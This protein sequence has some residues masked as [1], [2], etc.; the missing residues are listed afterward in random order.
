MFKNNFWNSTIIYSFGFL[1]LRA[2]SFL[3]LPLYTNILAPEDLGRVFIFITFLAFMNAIYA[4][5]MDTALLKYYDSE[6]NILSTS[7]ISIGIFA[8]PIS[9]LIYLNS[10]F[11]SSF[12][13][14]NSL[15]DQSWIFNNNLWALFAIAILFLDVISS[16]LITLVRILNIP[17]YYLAVATLNII[18][19]IGLNLYF[20]HFRLPSMKFDGV[21]LA[22]FYVAVIQCLAL[23]PVGIK[24][25]K[26]YRFNYSLFKKMI[27]FAWPFFPATLFFII[28]EMSD[29]IM[30]ERFLSLHDVGLYG[31]GYKIGALMLMIV[32]GFN[33]N[34]QPYYLKYGEN[35][36]NSAV[37]NF[38]YIGNVMLLVLIL[39]AGVLSSIWPMLLSIKIYSFSII[40]DGFLSGGR[41]IP[42]ILVSYVFYGFFIFQMP[43][44]Y[45]KNKQNWAPLLWGF[46]AIINIVGNIIL[47]PKLGY[48][49]AAISTLLAY[50]T[51]SIIL[52]YKNYSWLWIPYNF[53]ILF[54]S[55]MISLLQYYLFINSILSIYKIMILGIYV[56]SMFILLYIAKSENQTI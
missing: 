7:L 10:N 23:L 2:I 29:R 12:L 14:N 52:L 44:I 17:W 40:G 49:G 53:K 48:M 25:I 33:I 6:K 36:D 5:G 35:V 16:R 56:L 38:A 31:A 9:L 54:I 13:F 20:L 22:M 51:M 27:T 26:S 3:L 30:I 19:S 43:S 41:V 45:I 39:I 37:V 34:W 4:F 15:N 24:K 32:R 18:F 47:L 42:Y 8:I 1:F 50:C 55:I 21:I 11:I 28:I 46:G